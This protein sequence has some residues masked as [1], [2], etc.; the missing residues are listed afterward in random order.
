MSDS[1]IM[2]GDG[3]PLESRAAGVPE[4]DDARRDDMLATLAHEL[5]NPLVPLRAGVTIIQMSDGDQQQI[6]EQC[7][8]MERQIEHLSGIINDM[9]DASRLS[10]GNLVLDKDR[11]ELGGILRTAVD[12]NE[13]LLELSSHELRFSLPEGE[14][15]VEADAQRL[16][17]VLN[18]LLSNAIKYTP[19]GGRIRLAAKLERSEVCI[20]VA[21]SGLGIPAHKLQSVF[22]MFGQVDRSLETGYNGLGLGLH[23]V[24]AIVEL[25]GGRIEADSEGEGRGSVF[26]VWLPVLAEQR[27]AVAARAEAGT[28]DRT[29]SR[30]LLVDD[31]RDVARSLARLVRLLGHEIRVAFD[32]SE[33]LEIARAFKPS[34]VLM[35]IGMPGINGYDAARAMRVEPYGKDAYLVALTGWGDEKNRRMSLE[36]GF[37]RHLTK[38]VQSEVIEELL[39]GHP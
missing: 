31:N 30:V 5:R 2:R 33:A 3:R 34:V 25:H 22:E 8:I 19:Y 28:S 14:I 21:D 37:D 7:T 9:L 4:R 13:D 26:R 38:P 27:D 12:Q 16:L 36:A 11:V 17:Q 18:N 15:F 24:K 20:S 39:A 6:A 1:R 35:D 29:R 32:G 23:L 10:H